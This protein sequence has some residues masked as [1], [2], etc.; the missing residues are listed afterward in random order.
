MSGGRG[1]TFYKAISAP[2][3]ENQTGSNSKNRGKHM[4]V[5]V[6]FWTPKHGQTR[7]TINSN[8]SRYG[9][10]IEKQTSY[11]MSK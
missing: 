11:N 7:R 10:A 5:L 8:R 2:D 3:K 4:E 6:F 9:T 1:C